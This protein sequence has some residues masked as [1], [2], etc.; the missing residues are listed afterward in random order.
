MSMRVV[1]HV[2]VGRD[3]RGGQLDRRS[4][5]IRSAVLRLA[6][7]LLIGGCNA[8]ATSSVTNAHDGNA[9]ASTSGS[10][11]VPAT[12]ASTSAA[13]TNAP[14][15]SATASPQVLPRD[16]RAFIARRDECDHFR[17]EEPSDEARAAEL[18][19]KL[20]QTCTGTDAALAALRRDH[21]GEPAAIAALA[22]YEDSVE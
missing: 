6:P 5:C 2:T 15:P 1:T 12:V 13:S 7:I 3:P 9:L 4:R 11:D 18:E 16:V 20:K 22:N 19:R 21:A 14:A 10:I 8:P 17:G